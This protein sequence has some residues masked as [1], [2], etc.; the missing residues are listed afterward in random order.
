[1]SRPKGKFVPNNAKVRHATVR[2]KLDYA[3]DEELRIFGLLLLI[4]RSVAEAL[5]TIFGLRPNE[6]KYAWDRLLA[7]GRLSAIMSETIEDI[8]KRAGVK[9][10]SLIKMGAA[11]AK[12]EQTPPFVRAHLIL[13][14]SEQYYERSGVGKE[15]RQPTIGMIPL[16][17]MDPRVAEQLQQRAIDAKILPS[18]AEESGGNGRTVKLEEGAS[19]SVSLSDAEVPQNR[20]EEKSLSEDLGHS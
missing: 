15:N 14:M 11:M 3:R 16:G 18:P 20:P 9:I 6:A 10:E 12:D 1:M 2:R 17:I 5:K 13:R 8:W 7:T 19:V 4:G